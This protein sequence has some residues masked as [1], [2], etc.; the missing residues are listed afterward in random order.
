MCPVWPSQSKPKQRGQN[1]FDRGHELECDFSTCEVRSSW[2]WLEVDVFGRKIAHPL[3]RHLP[4]TGLSVLLAL[5]PSSECRPMLAADLQGLML[6]QI[7][8]L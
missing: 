5:L 6:D 2:L 7:L 8:M 1:I 3:P 4:E